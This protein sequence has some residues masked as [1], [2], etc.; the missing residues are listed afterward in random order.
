MYIQVKADLKR[1]K[2]TSGAKTPSYKLKTPGFGEYLVFWV[3]FSF[4]VFFF[5]P[6]CCLFLTCRMGLDNF[7]Q[8]KFLSIIP[9]FQLLELGKKSDECLEHCSVLRYSDI[10][11]S[12]SN[13]DIIQS[14]SCDPGTNECWLYQVSKENPVINK[15]YKWL[16]LV[17][18]FGSLHYKWCYGLWRRN[19]F[20]LLSLKK[21][22]NK[23]I[24]I[25]KLTGTDN[26]QI[27]RTD[28][29]KF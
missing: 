12:L 11:K 4:L 18:I 27:A 15:Y 9:F 29:N 21:K 8:D 16:L 13:S 14:F 6:V 22:F 7:F 10:P 2:V 20:L 25:C 3:F 17:Y 24:N 1:K 5:W 23:N 19:K 28:I 26:N